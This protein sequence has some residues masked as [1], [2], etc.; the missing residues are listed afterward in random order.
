VCVCVMKILTLAS[1]QLGHSEN[2]DCKE[3]GQYLRLATHASTH[4]QAD[5][6]PENI[7]PSVSVYKMDGDIIMVWDSMPDD[8]R[9][10]QDCESFRQGLKTWLFSR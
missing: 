8:L 1:L 3:V 9:A 5:K 4:A 2:V 10:K 6:Q 7:M